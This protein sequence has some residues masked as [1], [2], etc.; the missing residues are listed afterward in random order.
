MNNSRHEGIFS[1]AEFKNRRI[2]IIGLGNIGSH[3]AIALTRMG[4]EK[5]ALYDFDVV[6]DVNIATQAFNNNDKEQLK[7]FATAQHMEDINPNVE[8][9]LINEKLTEDSE[10]LVHP[11]QDQTESTLCFISGVDSMEVR[12]D[13]KTALRTSQ[14][15]SNVPVIDG[16]LGKEQC[17]VYFADKAEDWD[18][19]IRESSLAEVGCTEKYISYTPL[20]ISALINSTVKKMCLEQEIPSKVI[21]EFASNHYLKIN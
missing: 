12:E 10:C 16:R 8:I 14:A 7:I 4:F 18:L 9:E 11:A 17:E 19:D 15:Y 20:M 1:P 6:E 3:T 5:F 21:F 2:H 13:I